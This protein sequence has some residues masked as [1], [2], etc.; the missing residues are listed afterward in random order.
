MSR[1]NSTSVVRAIAPEDIRKGVYIAQ[2]EVIYQH[3]PPSCFE[4]AWQGD[5]QPVKTAWLP[6]GSNEPLEVIDVCLPFVLVRDVA[7]AVSSM[8]VRRYRLARLDPAYA[9]R[10]ARRLKAQHDDRRSRKKRKKRR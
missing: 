1:R 5:R 4:S 2:L 9:K 7:G 10:A 6:Y 8:D 3:L